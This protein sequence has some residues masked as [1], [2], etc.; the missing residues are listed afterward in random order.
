MI[1]M[2]SII[3]SLVEVYSW[4]GDKHQY[5]STFYIIG[6]GLT[7]IL[8]IMVVTSHYLN[9]EKDIARGLKP[10]L[11]VFSFIINLVIIIPHPF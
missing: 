6:H 7:I 4:V 9:R 2:L 5:E 10:G 3:L 1:T 11:R 8:G